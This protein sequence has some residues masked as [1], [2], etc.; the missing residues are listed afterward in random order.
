MEVD[1]DVLQAAL[2]RAITDSVTPEVQREVFQ[3][4]M[5]NFLFRADSRGESA[6][7]TEAFKRALQQA[8]ETLAKE[9]VMSPDNRA[10]IAKAVQDGLDDAMKSRTFIDN[11]SARIASSMSRY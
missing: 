5:T 4:A 1:K 11:I 6:P 9:I 2:A 7:I 3:K 10:K 8:T